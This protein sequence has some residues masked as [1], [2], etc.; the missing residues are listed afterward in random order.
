MM[1][2]HDVAT[3][4]RCLMLVGD[5]IYADA[6]AGV[7]DPTVMDDRFELPYEGLLQTAVVRHT[8]RRLPL[9][10]TVDDHE[11]DNNWEPDLLEKT[12]SADFRRMGLKAYF[13]V[14]R[15]AGPPIPPTAPH[16]LPPVGRYSNLG[17]PLTAFQVK[18]VLLASSPPMF[19]AVVD[20]SV[21]A[22][23]ADG[24]VS[25]TLTLPAPK[26]TSDGPLR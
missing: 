8:L 9:F 10:T 2:A 23:R 1:D 3:R 18:Q 26:A 12:K 6:T 22:G 16:V 14:Q 17:V 4:P 21:G 25:T 15:A 19:E 13:R 20:S 7:F 11:I 5:Q 24:G